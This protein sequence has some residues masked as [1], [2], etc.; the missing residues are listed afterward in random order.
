MSK[1]SR[2]IVITGVSRGLGRAMAEEF[3]AAGHQVAG[4]ARNFE[5][6]EQLQEQFGDGAYR[7]GPFSDKDATRTDHRHS[8]AAVDVTDETQVQAWHNMLRKLANTGEASLAAPDLLVN[9]AGSIEHPNPL[10]QVPT[11]EIDRV[12]DVNIKG[13]INTIRHFLPAMAARQSGIIVNFSS[14]WGRSASAGVAPYC[15]TKWAIEGMTRALAQELPSGMAA[16][17]LNPGIIHTDMLD[18]CFGKSAAQFPSV[19]AWVR[20]AVPFLLQISPRD[21]GQPLSVPI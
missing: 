10:W 2:Y 8:F 16:V 7:T 4:C 1:Q 19:Q 11:A 17:P 9:N 20:K 18:I 21:N 6:I 13:T 12:I 5:A 14:G 15:A 3:I